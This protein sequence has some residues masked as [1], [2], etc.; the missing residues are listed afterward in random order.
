MAGTLTRPRVRLT[1]GTIITTTAVVA[2]GIICYLMAAHEHGVAHF[3]GIDTQQSQNYNFMSG[4][5]PIIVT[6][7][8][9]GSVLGT[10]WHSINC[11]EH[12]C[13]R[14]GRHKINGT[15]WCNHHHTSA[16]PVRTEQEILESVDAQLSELVRLLKSQ[17]GEGK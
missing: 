13:W 7:L 12:G 2:T 9:S 6:L 14:F 11:H 15:P 5:G 16:R 17:S 1:R 10:I 3:L 4:F 8:L